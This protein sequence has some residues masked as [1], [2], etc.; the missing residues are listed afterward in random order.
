M[1]GPVF[2]YQGRPLGSPRLGIVAASRRA[3]IGHVSCHAFR[4]TC[5]TRLIN[6]GVDLPTVKAWLRHA[7]IATTMR[8]IH[9]A[10]LSGAAEKLAA[11]NE[12]RP[13]LAP[14]A[15]ASLAGEDVTD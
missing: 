13:A 15:V 3:G 7:S 12:T 2:M 6:A 10:D 14:G 11:F 4:H 9:G 1:G 8:Y 5:A